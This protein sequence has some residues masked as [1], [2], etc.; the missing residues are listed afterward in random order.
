MTINKQLHN[1]MYGQ[2]HSLVEQRNTSS[3]KSKL[4]RLR[5]GVGKIPGENHEIWGI[6]LNGMPEAFLSHDGTP[7]HAEW[8]VYLSLTMF[9]I[10]QQGYSESMHIDGVSLGRAVAQL[11]ETP[12]DDGEEC[13]RVLHRFGPI[14]T[15][16]NMRE[17][18]HYL[19]AMIKLLASKEIK[20]DYIKLAEDI[21]F[22]QNPE[23]R[24]K[25]Q[26]KWG[27]DFYI[28]NNTNNKG[29]N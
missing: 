17:F 2:I 26:L 23:S 15:A 21:Y 7:T 20:L 24:K 8:A 10:H 11:I 18:S 6:F 14:V 27:Q 29:E 3:G 9:A 4:A 12:D 16:K 22:F 25:V 5:R 13:E 1:Y 19:R 28:N